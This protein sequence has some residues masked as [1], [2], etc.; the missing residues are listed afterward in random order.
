MIRSLYNLIETMDLKTVLTI[1]GYLLNLVALFLIVFFER[2]NHTNSIVWVF[3]LFL[4]PAPIGFVLYLLFGR[5]PVFG[6]KARYFNRFHED[7]RYSSEIM[8]QIELINASD[9]QSQVTSLVKY[10]L[11]YNESLFSLRN[12]VQVFTDNIEQF[13]VLMRDIDSAQKFINLLFFAIRP[14]KCGERLRELLIK[15]AKQGI[16]I[17][18]VYDDFGSVLLYNE[19]F[20]ELREAGGRVVKFFPSRFKFLNINLNYRNHRKIVVIDN[21]IGHI[22]SANIGEQYLGLSKIKYWR[23]TTLRISGEAV[24]LLNLRIVEDFNFASKKQAIQPQPYAETTEAHPLLPIQIVS[25]GPDSPDP[26]IQ[27]CYIKAIYS[28]SKRVYIQTPYLIPDEV[29][30]EAIKAAIRS[31]VDVRI[32]I[33]GVPDKRIV[34]NCTMSYANELAAAGCK[35]YLW[36]GF[37]H[38]KVLLIDDEISSV[39][40]FNIDIRSFRLNFEVTAFVYDREVNRKLTQGFDRDIEESK[41]YDMEAIRKRPIHRKILQ[42][43]FRLLSPLF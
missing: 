33:P 4:F 13:E 19:F 5:G 12:S 42:R 30:M 20:D 7:A 32:I 18:L 22:G 43:V 25:D 29:F 15:K 26:I 8:R 28:A 38:S 23:D 37:M 2:K 17:N 24:F 11:R 31:N 9:A 36:K 41:L 27:S 16:E 34:Y 6:R 1:L 21:K 40:S 3:T 14:D 10:N 39:G 35:I